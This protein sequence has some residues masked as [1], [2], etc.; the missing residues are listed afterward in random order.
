[1]PS[2]RP[3]ALVRGSGGGLGL[4]IAP[5]LA[6]R[7]YVVAVTDFDGAAAA[8]AAEAIG[9]GAWSMPLAVTDADECTAAARSAV[10]RSG[11]LDAWA[12]NAGVLFPGVSYEQDT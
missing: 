10:E 9:A 8:R 6:K 11:S 5:I 7:G 2:T 3:A 12:Y 4:A 1:M